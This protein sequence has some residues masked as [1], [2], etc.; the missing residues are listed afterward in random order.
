MKLGVTRLSSAVRLALSLGAVMA[1]GASGT[2]F[3]QDQST[4]TQTTSTTPPA[5]Q[6]ASTLQTVVVT[7]SHIRRVDLETAS[8]VVTIDR[9]AIKASGKLTLGDLVQDLPAVTGG[10]T[11]PQVNN[12]GGTG[13][14]SIG[15]RGLGP[16]RTLILVDGHRVMGISLGGVITTPVNGDAPDANSIPAAMIDHID[17]LT[18][19]AS[20]IYGS[21]AVGGVVNFILRK[22][23]QGAEFSTNFG[24]SDHDDGEQQG[25]TFTF[26]RRPTRAASWAA[27]TTTRRMALRPAVA[28]S[29]GMP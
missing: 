20:S 29:P 21:D 12:G 24:Q 25:Y 22:D 5:P 13:A 10:N 17:V 19:G 15:L 23:Y 4:T 27:S 26:A 3:A 9:A 14:T 2:A 1:V 18:T 11:N 16:N 6:K 28:L 8:P 7:G